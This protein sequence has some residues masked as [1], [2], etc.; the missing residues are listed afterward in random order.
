MKTFLVFKDDEKEDLAYA[1]Q[2]ASLAFA[3]HDLDNWLRSLHK[4]EEKDTVD[5]MEVR[6]KLR[7][8][9]KDHDI[10]VVI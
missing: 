5:V 7:E 1:Q 2:G 4:Y 6:R 9:L 3:F 8:V 10:T